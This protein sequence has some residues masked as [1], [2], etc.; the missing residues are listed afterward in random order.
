MLKAS[1]SFGF[2]FEGDIAKAFILGVI[3]GSIGSDVSVGALK[4]RVLWQ[5]GDKSS[6]FPELIQALFWLDE[7]KYIRIIGSHTTMES[8]SVRALPKV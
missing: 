3:R 7:R 1:N 2:G 5:W 4:E 8:N 6:H